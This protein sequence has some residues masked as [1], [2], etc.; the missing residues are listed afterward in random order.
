MRFVSSTGN[1][2]LYR[3]MIC[4]VCS[5]TPTFRRIRRATTQKGTRDFRTT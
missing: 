4:F 3:S 1:P 5:S 2:M